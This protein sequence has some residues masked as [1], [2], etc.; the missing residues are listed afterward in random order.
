[1]PK[2]RQISLVT[3]ILCALLHAWFGH[4]LLHGHHHQDLGEASYSTAYKSQ[5]DQ[6]SS[7]L[8]TPALTTDFVLWNLQDKGYWIATLEDFEV[9][10]QSYDLLDAKQVPRPPPAFSLIA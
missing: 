1:M 6:F 10:F 4:D 8:G 3:L 7:L 5:A 9:T 2:L